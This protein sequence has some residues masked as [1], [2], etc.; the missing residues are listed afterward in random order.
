MKGVMNKKD[1]LVQ[2]DQKAA[3]VP[4]KGSELKI[5]PEVSQ[6]DKTVQKCQE[7][8]QV[9]KKPTRKGKLVMKDKA[10]SK[11]AN[12]KKLKSFKTAEKNKKP[13]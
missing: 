6:Q 13:R 11:N 7:D 10:D 2:N 1:N 9:L 5:E 4:E 8:I 3:L 12:L